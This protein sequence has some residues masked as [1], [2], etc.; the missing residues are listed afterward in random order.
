[1]VDA[2]REA[3]VAEKPEPGRIHSAPALAER[4]GVSATP[5]REAMV[6]LTQEGPVETLRH[7]GYR[8]GGRSPFSGGATLEAVGGAPA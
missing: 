4:L 2:L 5:V 1:M 8:V 7:R 3:M 6:E